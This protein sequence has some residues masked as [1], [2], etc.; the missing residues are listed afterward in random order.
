MTADI[1]DDD[2][3]REVERKEPTLIPARPHASRAKEQELI[4]RRRAEFD[5]FWNEEWLPRIW[6]EERRKQERRSRCRTS[7]IS[8]LNTAPNE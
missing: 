2:F 8:P 7:T 5:R 1:I 3:Y 4:N 6:A